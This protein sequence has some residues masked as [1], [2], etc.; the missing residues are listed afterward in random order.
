MTKSKVLLA[1]GSFSPVPKTFGFFVPGLKSSEGKSNPT[2][3]Q[4]Q[5]SS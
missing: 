2:Y 5:F 1:K 4:L 3:L